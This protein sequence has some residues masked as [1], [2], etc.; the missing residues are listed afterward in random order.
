MLPLVDQREIEIDDDFTFARADGL[1]QQAPIGCDDRSEATAGDRADVGDAS[2]RGNFS[3][4][5]SIQP[6]RSANDK[7]PRLGANEPGTVSA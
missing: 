5:V 1:T 3:L 6:C 2:V 7:A 4:L